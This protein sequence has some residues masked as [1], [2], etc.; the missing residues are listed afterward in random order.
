MELSEEE[1]GNMTY[2]A[3]ADRAKNIDF[4]FVNSQMTDWIDRWNRLINQ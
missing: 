3:V 1:A 4:D 2:G